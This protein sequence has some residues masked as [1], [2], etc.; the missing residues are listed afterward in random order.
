MYN[1][2]KKL[3]QINLSIAIAWFKKAFK[4][5]HCYLLMGSSVCLKK[6]QLKNKRKSKLTIM[7]KARKKQ[8]QSKNS[9]D[10]ELWQATLIVDCV[11]AF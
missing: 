6:L 7:A 10:Q 8:R 2:M 9:F 5:Q 11:E 3:T 1:K 4:L